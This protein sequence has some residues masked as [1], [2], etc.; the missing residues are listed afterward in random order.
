V[1][2]ILS[3]ILFLSVLLFATVSADQ[4]GIILRGRESIWMSKRD[5]TLADLMEIEV[6]PESDSEAVIALGK[7]K[8]METVRI[9]VIPVQVA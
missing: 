4:S 7:I 3:A 5:V 1:K 2:I 9:L 8:V 6:G